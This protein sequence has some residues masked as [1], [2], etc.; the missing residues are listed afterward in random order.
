MKNM[1]DFILGV[2]TELA[3][4]EKVAELLERTGHSSMERLLEGAV[5]ESENFR[6][7]LKVAMLEEGVKLSVV[8][9]LF[10]EAEEVMT[11]YMEGIEKEGALRKEAFLGALIRQLKA[12]VLQGLA[13]NRGFLAGGKTVDQGVQGLIRSVAPGLSPGSTKVMGDVHRGTLRMGLGNWMEGKGMSGLGSRVQDWGEGAMGRHATQLN[14]EKFTKGYNELAG[15]WTQQ[16]RSAGGITQSTR[17]KM[18]TFKNLSPGAKNDLPGAIP[19]N[20]I[21]TAKSRAEAALGGA[22]AKR[23]APPSGGMVRFA[24]GKGLK[25][26]L[27]GAGVGGLTMGPAGAVLGGLGGMAQGTLGTG[28][29]ALAAGGLGAA[30]LWGAGKMFGGGGEKDST[31]LP[32]DRNR[33]LPFAGNNWTGAVSGALLASIL[34][35]EMGLSGP[36]SWMLPLLG[37]VAGYK[38]LPGAINSWKDP[39]G[40][41]VN[42]IPQIQRGGNLDRFGYRPQP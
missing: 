16:G 35:R 18:E 27:I 20:V 36:M 13:K 39:K 17:N 31:G 12:P 24:P 37:G 29:A 32:Q 22:R 30:G 4:E 10:K 42:A 11:R 2:K 1:E 5:K 28:G 34:G 21:E 26:G 6:E 23:I 19:A 40:Q 14:T 9:G 41:G 3:G 25:R 7:G 33:V 15:K 38:M 8:E